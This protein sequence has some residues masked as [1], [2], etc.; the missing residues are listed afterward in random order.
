MAT[1]QNAGAGIESG[2]N[3]AP[4]LWVVDYDD[5][6]WGEHLLELRRVGGRDLLVDATLF[7]TQLPT[8]AGEA[9]E[10]VVDPLRDTEEV[11]SSLHDS[12]AHIKIHAARIGE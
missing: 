2:P 1:P 10:V 9:V 6:V 8:V 12:P 3:Q 11:L 4:R 7:L 5:V